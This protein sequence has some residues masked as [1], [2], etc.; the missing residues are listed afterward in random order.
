[1][2]LICLLFITFVSCSP[3]LQNERTVVDDLGRTINIPH[4]I[5]RVAPLAPSI[6]ELL[7]ASGA[8]SR[9]VGVSTVDDF[10]P[11][12]DSLPKY[13]LIPMDIEAIVALDLDLIVASEQ[14]NTLRDADTFATVGI[15]V[16]FVVIDSLKDITKSIKS[17]GN[18]FGTSLVATQ[19]AAEL[20]DSLAQLKSLTEGIT[21]KPD[22]LF[23]IEHTT[24]YAFGDGS[25][26]H[27]IIDWAGGYSL[28]QDIPSRFPILTDEFV[29]ASQPA[30]I[31]GTFG[32][33]IDSS[34]LL[35]YHPTWDILPAVQSGRIYGFDTANYQRPGPRLVRGAWELAEKLHPHIV[36]R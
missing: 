36:K 1:M 7:F 33:H 15:P 34:T 24:L 11:A 20:E 35:E 19:R 8:G 28:T 27:D 13:S 14:V 30:V 32:S 12:V 2:R 3:N 25:Y 4:Q 31:A 18:L 10:P 26:I 5:Q 29:L 9:V 22:L 16:Y 17:L 23:L 21:H 6:T